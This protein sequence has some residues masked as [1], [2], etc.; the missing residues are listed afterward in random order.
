MLRCTPLAAT[1]WLI[2]AIGML[3]HFYTSLWNAGTYIA[4]AGIVMFL[5]SFSVGFSS[6]PW[7]VNTEIYPLHIVGTGQ[8]LS[9]TTNWLSNF[10]VSSVFL[11]FLNTDLGSVLAFLLLAL[12]AALAFVFVYFMV[13]ETANKQIDDILV[14]ILGQKYKDE[15]ANKAIAQVEQEDETQPN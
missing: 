14:E 6:Q 5:A 7:T 4:F 9:T 10:V 11:I 8:S 1:S 13:P 2:T 3:L 15:L 12:F